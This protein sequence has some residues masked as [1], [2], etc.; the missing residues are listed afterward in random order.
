MWGRKDTGVDGRIICIIKE[1]SG[2]CGP[3]LS[4]GGQGQVPRPC[5]RGNEHSDVI[6]SQVFLG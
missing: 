6:K 1:Y 3:D 4:G 5:E 2:M